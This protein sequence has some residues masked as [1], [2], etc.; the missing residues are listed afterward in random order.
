MR[1]LNLNVNAQ[2]LETDS[3]LSNLVSGTSGYLIAKFKFSKEWDGCSKILTFTYGD[4]EYS[5]VLN[6]NDYLIPK[7][8]LENRCFRIHITGVKDKYMIKTTKLRIVQKEV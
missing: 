4:N 3:D 1:I 8:V 6:S 7:E 2:V 5:V